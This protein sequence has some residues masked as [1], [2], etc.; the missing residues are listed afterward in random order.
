[1]LYFFRSF[2]WE[3][4]W[5]M[6]RMEFWKWLG[7]TNIQEESALMRTRQENFDWESELRV[8]SG[9]F[10]PKQLSHCTK[11]WAKRKGLSSPCENTLHS[12]IPKQQGLG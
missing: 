6:D 4:W 2:S 11:A 5:F 8:V 3:Y 1:V 10:V 7:D 12:P 9:D